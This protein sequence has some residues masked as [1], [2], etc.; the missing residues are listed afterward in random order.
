MTRRWLVFDYGEVICTRTTA[1]PAL[2]DRMGVPLAEFEAAYWAGRDAY[3]RG[4]SDLEFWRT[5]GDATGVDVNEPLSA[6]LTELDIA[7]WAQVSPATL[8]LL[9]SLAEAGTALALLSNAPVSFARFAE[10]QPWTRHFR[11]L[12]FSGDVGL[13]K[14]DAEI[15][16]LLV[17]RLDAEPGDCLFLDDRQVNVDGA[18]AAGLRAQ[19]WQGIP[20]ELPA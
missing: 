15:F 10:R 19:L 4:A 17:S 9:Q 13:A 2:A 14:P 5:V 11:E 3:D 20:A 12:L 6:E 1:L 7:G 18:R 16:E 8:E